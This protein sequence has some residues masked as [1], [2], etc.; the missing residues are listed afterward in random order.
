MARYQP[1]NTINPSSRP[2]AS[3]RKKKIKEFDASYNLSEV[4][5]RQS[6]VRKAVVGVPYS[7]TFVRPSGS[8]REAFSPPLDGILCRGKSLITDP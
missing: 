4:I 6:L 2:I 3:T 7:A 8:I 1:S 5:L